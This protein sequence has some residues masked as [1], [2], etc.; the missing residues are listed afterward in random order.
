MKKSFF[1]LTAGFLIFAALGPLQA[2]GQDNGITSSGSSDSSPASLSSAGVEELKV[3]DDIPDL[4]AGVWQ[5]KDRLVLFGKDGNEFAAVLRVFYAWYNDRAA[6]PASYAEYSTRDRNNTTSRRAEHIEIK[7]ITLAE[8]E[9][10]TAGAYELR[11]LYP[12]EKAYTYVPVAIIGG[13]I[14]LDFL[15]K[16]SASEVDRQHVLTSI[17]KS[18]DERGG[19]TENL[20]LEG[21]WRDCGAASG[22]LVSPPYI[23]KERT[24]YYFYDNSFYHIRYWETDMPY[25]Y[26]RAGFTDG[27]KS[28]VV[29]KYVR[30][31][32]K[33]Y[34]CCTG[35]RTQ[36]RNI[37]KSSELPSTCL[38][39]SDGVIC[40]FGPPYLVRVDGSRKR[41][42]L[43]RMTDET[44]AKRKPPQKPPFPVTFPNVRWPKYEELELYNPD[45][46][47]RRNIDV[48]K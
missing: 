40:A 37:Q 20:N 35:R 18:T 24:G 13:N 19:V 15:V 47:N 14:Y 2:F 28:F 39:D 41:E 26:A 10:H 3:S 38:F 45:T 48:G 11:V 21:F 23:K 30:S 42:D 43:Q 29:D 12:G 34:T 16:G 5:G 36:I 7:Y 17:S 32:G 4:L 9:S 46:W 31:A 6:E 27:D 1:L 33:V 44:N 8:N 25:S 22:L